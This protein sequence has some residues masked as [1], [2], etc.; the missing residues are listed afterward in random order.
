MPPNYHLTFSFSGTN[1]RATYNWL[2]GGGNVAVP[3]L[4]EVPETWLGWPTIDG[5]SHDLRFL[6]PTRGKVVALKAKGP[7]RRHP[8]SA[9]LGENHG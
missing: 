8:E 9:F 6:D 7:L 2:K 3:F 1:L 5:D 4:V